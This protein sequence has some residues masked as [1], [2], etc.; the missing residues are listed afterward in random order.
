MQIYEF[1]KAD[2]PLK[3]FQIQ[4]L[5]YKC[6]RICII[7]QW[8]QILN[9]HLHLRMEPFPFP[10]PKLRGSATYIPCFLIPNLQVSVSGQK[11]FY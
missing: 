11:T 3:L 8:H 5:T 9:L 7:L 10:F 6:Q 2:I 4:Q 1:F